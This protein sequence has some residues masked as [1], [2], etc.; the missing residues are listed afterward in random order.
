MK[1]IWME[2]NSKKN[3]LKY[4]KLQQGGCLFETG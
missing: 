2:K 3:P 4:D 1:K